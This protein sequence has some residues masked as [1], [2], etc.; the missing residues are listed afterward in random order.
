MWDDEC[1]PFVELVKE[2]RWVLVERKIGVD[3]CQHLDLG[4]A[5]E[6]VA[7]EGGLE[8]PAVLGQRSPASSRA[9]LGPIGLHRTEVDESN[10][11]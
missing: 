6:Q 9:K 10:M 7:A 8:S 11:R 2:T 4:E 3:V 5:I 1:R